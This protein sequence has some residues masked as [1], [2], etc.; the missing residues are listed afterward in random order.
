L[1]L[2]TPWG[3]KLGLEYESASDTI[4]TSFSLPKGFAGGW[5]RLIG[6]DRAHN[7]REVRIYLNSQGGIDKVEP[8]DQ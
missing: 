1:I 7:R 5:F 8:V 4:S 2:L 3:E 6:F